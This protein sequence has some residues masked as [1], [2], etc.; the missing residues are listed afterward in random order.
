M[1]RRYCSNAREFHG[2]AYY[3][4]AISSIQNAIDQLR[5]IAPETYLDRA[6]VARRAAVAQIELGECE[7]DRFTLGNATYRCGRY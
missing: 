3:P 4:P 2:Q 7:Q 1:T 5:R 6:T